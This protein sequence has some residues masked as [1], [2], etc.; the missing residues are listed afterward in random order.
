MAKTQTSSTKE[1]QLTDALGAA[2]AALPGLRSRPAQLAMAEA[3][4]LA[5][6]EGRP[7]LVHAPTGVGKSLGYLVPLAAAGIRTTVATA[8]KAL[9]AQLVANDLPRL[10]ETFGTTYALALGRGNFYCK[11][12]GQALW[13]ATR[14]AATPAE[15]AALELVDWASSSLTGLRT[16]APLG[17]RDEAWDLVSVSGEDCPGARGCALARTCFAEQAR[18]LAKGADVVVTNHHLLLL[19]LELRK[20]SDTAGV[21]LPP[22]DVIV[23]DEAHRLAANASELYGVTVRGSRAGRAG[24]AVD[25]VAKAGGRRTDW[26]RRLRTVWDE[27]TGELR[28]GPVLPGSRAAGRLGEALGRVALEAAAAGRALE[29]LALNGEEFEAGLH[30]A[31]RRTAG[32]VRDLRRLAEVAV[33]PA[34]EASTTEL[35]AWIE[36]GRQEGDR[37]VRSALVDP[38]DILDRLLWSRPPAPQVEE[39]D[40]GLP[41]P[42]GPPGKVATIACSATLAVAG[43]LDPAAKELGVSDPET[44]VE[45]SP[46]DFEHN[47]LLYVPTG[48]PLPTSDSF[49]SASTT[50]LRALVE[51]SS[52]RALVLC[53]S[54]RAVQTLG[55]GLAGLPYELLIQGTDTASRLVERFRDEVGSVLVGTRM[56]FEGIDVAGESLSLLVLD[57]LP[58]AP[59]DDPLLA[60]RGRRVQRSGGRAFDELSLPMAAVSMQQAVGRLIRT[61]SDRGVMAVLDRRLADAAYGPTLLASLPPAPLT[62]SR[63]DVRR[64]FDPDPKEGTS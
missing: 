20:L 54:W 17:T 14:L 34:V 23:I 35:A 1:A 60:E 31:K 3:V 29:G 36:P 50:E 16:E 9:Q 2:F 8:T 32:L 59:P 56:F 64:F 45:G 33:T 18:E 47:A 39:T 24:A 61:E 6:A 52:G 10:H 22:T 28:P 57:K 55:E 19:E 42:E 25:A 58:F 41:G 11:A 21:M 51:A 37:V 15:E 7:L 40:G 38:G 12:K 49:A 26:G 53:T 5:A 62:R 43:S 48:I 46:F 30:A 63:D 27:A 44:L 13:A 4:A